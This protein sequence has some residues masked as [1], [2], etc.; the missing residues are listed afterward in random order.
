MKKVLIKEAAIIVNRDSFNKYGQIIAPN[1]FFVLIFIC[2]FLLSKAKFLDFLKLF[3]FGIDQLFFFV[4]L[5]SHL[6]IAFGSRYIKLCFINNIV[7]LQVPYFVGLITAYKKNSKNRAFFV[8]LFFSLIIEVIMNIP[9]LSDFADSNFDP[10]NWINSAMEQ[11]GK[12]KDMDSILS[13][14]LMD[15][16][17]NSQDCGDTIESEMSALLGKLPTM[18]R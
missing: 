6:S 16:Q 5:F 8:V 13:G 4:F 12:S 15:I 1:A 17:V 9:N 2:T 10:Y 11:K 18:V 14:L 7:V 3:Y